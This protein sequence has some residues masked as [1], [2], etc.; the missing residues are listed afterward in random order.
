MSE[1]TDKNG[2][3]NFVHFT[4]ETIPWRE[5]PLQPGAKMAVLAGDLREAGLYIQRVKYPAGALTPAHYHPDDRHVVVLEGTWYAGFG[6]KADSVKAKAFKPGDYLMQPAGAVHFDGALDGDCV[7]QI[8][9][10]GPTG[11]TIVEKR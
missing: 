11:I 7:V 5:S 10:Y 9:G 6:D 3:R 4:D 8:T 1:T 2:P